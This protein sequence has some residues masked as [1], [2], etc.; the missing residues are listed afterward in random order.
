MD[1]GEQT[2]IGAARPGRGIVVDLDGYREPARALV[3]AL[4][5]PEPI[6]WFLCRDMRR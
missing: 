1:N 6:P 2:R 4:E 5:K 3:S